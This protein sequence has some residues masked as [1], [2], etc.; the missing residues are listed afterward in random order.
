M[1]RAVGRSVGADKLLASA[2]QSQQTRRATQTQLHR[3]G[4]RSRGFLLLTIQKESA[5]SISCSSCRCYS[6]RM[7]A[8]PTG[9]L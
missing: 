8:S 6:E 4:H 9:R 3:R 7:C 5:D 1:L 2:I